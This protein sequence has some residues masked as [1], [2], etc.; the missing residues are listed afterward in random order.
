MKHKRM[1]SRGIVQQSGEEQRRCAFNHKFHR[2]TQDLSLADPWALYNNK[3]CVFVNGKAKGAGRPKFATFYCFEER[4]Y[5]A[6]NYLLVDIDRKINER[7]V[8]M[9]RGD[10]LDKVE[11]IMRGVI[12]EISKNPESECYR[13]NQLYKKAVKPYVRQIFKY[14]Q[15]NEFNQNVCVEKWL[16]V[17]QELLSRPEFENFSEDIK[18]NYLTF[19]SAFQFIFDYGYFRRREKVSAD[20]YINFIKNTHALDS[21]KEYS[22]YRNCTARIRGGDWIPV[23]EDDI[24]SSV[25]ILAEWFTDYSETKGLNPIELAVIMHCEIVRIQAFPDGNHRLARLVANEI[26]VQADFP[27]VSIGLDE[28]DRYNAATNKAIE[29]HEIDDLLEIYYE[30]VY[31]NAQRMDK[32]FN[33]LDQKEEKTEKLAEK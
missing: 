3:K 9:S 1:I 11:E 29:T 25:R 5:S 2:V 20:N 12:Y 27:S 16:Q 22:A 17:H 32:C 13:A 21:G 10:E 33:K 23:S 30:K 19:N 8:G 28:R 15:E 6:L 14:F 18:K 7:R 4:N 24:A 31:A 26:L